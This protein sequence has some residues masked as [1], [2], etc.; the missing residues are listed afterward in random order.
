[1]TTKGLAARKEEDGRDQDSYCHWQYP[2]SLMHTLLGLALGFA[3]QPHLSKSDNDTLC[4]TQRGISNRIQCEIRAGIP[5][6]NNTEVF[7]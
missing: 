3:G 7:A 1:L 5:C 2:H 4:K 6:L